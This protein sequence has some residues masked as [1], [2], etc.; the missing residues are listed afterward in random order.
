MHVIAMENWINYLAGV[1]TSNI[2]Y[3]M[4]L[5]LELQITQWK[6]DSGGNMMKKVFVDY[7]DE[8]IIR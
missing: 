3:V 2:L 6:K 5:S 8:N 7:L 4:Y 1:L